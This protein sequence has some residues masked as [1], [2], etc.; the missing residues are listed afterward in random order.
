MTQRTHSPTHPTRAQLKA[1]AIFTLNMKKMY[2]RTIILSCCM[3]LRMI[4]TTMLALEIE[5]SRSWCWGVHIPMAA[6]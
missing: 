1:I 4:P 3:T 2:T 5:H 6:A